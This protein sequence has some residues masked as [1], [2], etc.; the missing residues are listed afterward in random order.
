MN[1]YKLTLSYDGTKF[2]GWQKQPHQITVQG[3]LEKALKK[4]TKSD[5][6]YS[7][8]SGRTDRGVHA[9][10]QIV[11]IEIPFAIECQALRRALNGLLPDEISVLA[12][13]PCPAS[14]HPVKEAIQKEYR[15]FFRLN[16]KNELP[17]M[18]NRFVDVFGEFDIEAMSRFCERFVGEHDFMNYFCT[19]TPV[20]TTVRTIYACELTLKSASSWPFGEISDLYELR[21]LGTG[22]LK[23]M[24]RLIV[25]AMWE[26][27]KGKFDLGHLEKS[28]L[29]PLPRKLGP[30]APAKGLYLYSVTY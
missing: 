24:V 18:N 15:Y 21:I 27:G 19:G 29:V 12:I 17:L 20:N 7:I 22:F 26:C 2:F 9:L 6:I 3:E 28:F 8:G 4:I 1:T 10:E 5:Q 14:F 16:P 25:G 23:Q 13:C 11:R 30:V